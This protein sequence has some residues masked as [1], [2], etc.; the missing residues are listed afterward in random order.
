MGAAMLEAVLCASS[1]LVEKN[2]TAK[3]HS[4]DHKRYNIIYAPNGQT[5]M[6]LYMTEEQSPDFVIKVGSQKG[7]TNEQLVQEGH[8]PVGGVLVPKNAVEMPNMTNVSGVSV[9]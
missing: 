4:L 2:R 1:C 3:L 5:P 6:K 8:K 9:E 7:K